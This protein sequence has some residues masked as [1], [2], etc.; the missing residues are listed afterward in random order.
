[1]L[2]EAYVIAVKRADGGIPKLCKV[3][4]DRFFHTEEEALEVLGGIE[5]SSW[6]IYR[7]EVTLYDE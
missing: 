6:A 7:I 3:F 4:G 1:M 5:S 2:E